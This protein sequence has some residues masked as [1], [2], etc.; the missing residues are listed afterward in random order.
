MR[1][2]PLDDPTLLKKRG[3]RHQAARA[4]VFMLEI[5]SEA[6][7]CGRTISCAHACRARDRVGHMGDA[8]DIEFVKDVAAPQLDL[9]L[10]I[11]RFDP[12]TQVDQRIAG[13]IEADR[14]AEGCRRSRLI[15]DVYPERKIH[16]RGHAVTIIDIAIQLP[17]RG[18]G[19]LLALQIHNPA[20]RVDSV[21]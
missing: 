6:V 13:D 19:E 14:M 2:S 11:G 18:R 7:A 3:P 17:F 16:R 10:A 15:A 21:G 5:Q 12:T 8:V 1:L 4:R 9:P 20:K